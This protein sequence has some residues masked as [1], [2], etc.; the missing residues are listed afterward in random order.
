[1]SEGLRITEETVPK[2]GPG[3]RLRED[4]ARGQ[5]SLM[6]PERMYI[7]DDIG[8]VIVQAM[9][10]ETSIGAMADDFAERFGAPRNEVLAD[11]IDMLQNFADK[12]VVSE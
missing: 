1:M 10:G 7:L 6:A 12:G 9:D 5:W 2:L 8:L 3:V 4:K 11:V